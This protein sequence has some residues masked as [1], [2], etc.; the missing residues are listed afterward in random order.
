MLSVETEYVWRTTAGSD[1]VLGVDGVEDN[2]DV[3]ARV[4]LLRRLTV[5]GVRR[6][7]GVLKRP[8][9]AC[10]GVVRRGVAVLSVDIPERLGNDVKVALKRFGEKL[11]RM[12]PWIVL[13][14]HR[15]GAADARTL[16]LTCQPPPPDCHR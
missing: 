10:I 15:G 11:R 6:R 12:G 3:R 2:D 5:T 1:G 7:V 13:N 14:A 4:R 9:N 16:L 8:D